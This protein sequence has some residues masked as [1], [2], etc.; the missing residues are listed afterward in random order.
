MSIDFNIV[1][2][3]RIKQPRNTNDIDNLTEYFKPVTGN[4]KIYAVNGIDGNAII[5]PQLS[6]KSMTAFTS[7][8]DVCFK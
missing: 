4:N 1:G 7:P 6:N 8:D 5:G 3:H 2:I